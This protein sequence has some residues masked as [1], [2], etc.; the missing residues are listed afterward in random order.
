[1]ED[2]SRIVL[3]SGAT[4]SLNTVIKGFLKP[5]MKVLTS[6]MEHNSVMRPLTQLARERMV[7]L[8]RF[9]SF[10]ESGRP[11]MKDFER[12]L[13]D[14]PDLLVMTAASNVCGAVFPLEE[15]CFLA[16]KKGSPRL[17]GRGPGRRRNGTPSR[18]LGH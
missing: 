1:M 11:D 13:A 6:S 5:G 10:A 7:G 12:Q 18:T 4:E 2:S 17:C 3:T 8:S 16:R 14:K 9:G 15:M